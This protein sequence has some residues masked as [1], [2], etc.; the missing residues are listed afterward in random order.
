MLSIIVPTKKAPNR[1]IIK[2]SAVCPKQFDLYGSV[3]SDFH[4]PKNKWVELG[5]L[6]PL[7]I[8]IQPIWQLFHLENGIPVTKFLVSV[9][10]STYAWV[11][12]L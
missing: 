12:V 11:D 10:V 6:A 3:G 7:P 8:N 4:S 2:A 9:L 1:R 5:R